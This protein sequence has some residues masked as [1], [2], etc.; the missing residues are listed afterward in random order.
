MSE[1][2]VTARA[3]SAAKSDG[4]AECEARSVDGDVDAFGLLGAELEFAGD[5]G[6]VGFG[7]VAFEGVE[8][9]AAGEV[10]RRSGAT[11]PVPATAKLS[12]TLRWKVAL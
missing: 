10:R 2:I 11:L 12:G 3:T 4:F 7:C 8:Q 6:A 9:A 1:N 5:E